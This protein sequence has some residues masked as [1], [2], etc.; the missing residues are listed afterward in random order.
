DK[1]NRPVVILPFG[2]WNMKKAAA[3]GN[4]EQCIRYICQ[5]WETLQRKMK[6]KRTSEGVPM[7]QFN[8]IGDFRGLGLKTVGSFAVL[9]VFKGIVGQFDPNYPEVLYKCY[10]INAS[11]A[12][13]ILWAV[14]EYQHSCTLEG[15]AAIIVQ[16]PEQM[17]QLEV[18]RRS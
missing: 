6:G 15:R 14:H 8:V 12:F 2:P 4:H 18:N 16:F 5:V 11:R 9:E 7:T 3:D 10:V 13:Q 1:E 17:N